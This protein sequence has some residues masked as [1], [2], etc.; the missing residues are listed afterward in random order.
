MKT[1]NGLLSVYICS[2]SYGPRQQ[3]GGG[4]FHFFGNA[5]RRSARASGPCCR[6][7]FSYMAKPTEP[8]P[9]LRDPARCAG[10]FW[11]GGFDVRSTR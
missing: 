6:G 5:F 4:Y 8:K 2:A 11:A 1:Q 3:V 7:A 9:V 10:A